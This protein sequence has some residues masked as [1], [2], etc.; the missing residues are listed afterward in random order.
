MAIVSFKHKGL[1]LF[2]TTGSIKAIQ[3]AHTKKLRVILTALTSATCL[4]MLKAPAFKMHSFKGE[5][6]GSYSIRL[7]AI[8]VLLF[9]LSE[10]TL[11]LLI[12]KITLDEGNENKGCITPH[13]RAKF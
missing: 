13:I 12:I 2:Y 6:I 7:T 4:E 11:S 1:K 5:C 10:Q 9:A 8:G 3:L